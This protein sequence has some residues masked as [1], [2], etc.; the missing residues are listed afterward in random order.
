ME[1]GYSEQQ[2]ARAH[3]HS[4]RKKIDILDALAMQI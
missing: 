4:V 2:V 1:M 3:E